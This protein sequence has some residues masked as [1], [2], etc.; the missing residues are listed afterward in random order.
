MSDYF[1]NWTQQARKGFIELAIL[2]LLCDGERYGYDLVKNL[3]RLPGLQVAEGTIYPL[4]SRLKTKGLVETFKKPSPDGPER[5]YY[6]L[7]VAGRESLN[8]MNEYAQSLI[9]VCIPTTGRK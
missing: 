8:L 5:K 9:G 3:V 4:L 7:T 1:D 6:A 2:N